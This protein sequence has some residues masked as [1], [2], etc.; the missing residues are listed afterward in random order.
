MAAQVTATSAKTSR[1]G[2]VAGTL[3]A[4]V[5]AAAIAASIVYASG[6]LEVELPLRQLLLGRSWSALTTHRRFLWVVVVGYVLAS[7]IHLGGR[8]RGHHGSA[9]DG[10]LKCAVM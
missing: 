1:T 10:T 9:N 5:A 6:L 3:L 2:G 8:R 7:A 4:L